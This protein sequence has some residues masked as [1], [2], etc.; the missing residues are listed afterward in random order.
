MRLWRRWR[1]LTAGAV[2]ASALIGSIASCGDDLPDGEQSSDPA[3]VAVEGVACAHETMGVGIV[4]APG[5]V[6]T[7]AHVV[8]G[9]EELN[10]RSGDGDGT[11]VQVVAFDPITDLALLAGDGVGEASVRLGS[12][13]AADLVRVDTIVDGA[14]V[15]SPARVVR[16]IVAVGEDIY[17]RD[18]A[19]RRVLELDAE[20]VEGDSG[21]GVFDSGGALVGVLFARSSSGQ[22]RAYAVAA[23]EVEA[24]LAGLG[25][26]PTPVEVG[27][28]L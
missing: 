17:R 20:V 27:P 14:L 10:T 4:V 15:S 25:P 5:L 2:V 19:R 8:A 12:A 21:A 18:G 22:G 26:D 16:P 13:R 1:P 28:C 9:A 11:P 7:N 23:S 6:V 3:V 24:L